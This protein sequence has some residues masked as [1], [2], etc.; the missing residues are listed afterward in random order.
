MMNSIPLIFN[1]R[2]IKRTSL[3]GVVDKDGAK[4]PVSA[5]LLSRGGNHYRIKML[6]VLLQCGFESIISIC[7]VLAALGLGC[8]VWAFL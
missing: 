8:C 4:M 3:G 6:N 2:Q 1:E 5:V 7:F